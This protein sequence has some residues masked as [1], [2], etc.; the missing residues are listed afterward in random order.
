MTFNQHGNTMLDLIAQQKLL[1]GDGAVLRD[2]ALAA[3]HLEDAL[4][5]YNSAQ[6]RR[7][8]TWNRADPDFGSGAA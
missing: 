8:G 4:T 5:R 7:K 1:E 3:T 2:L 6:Y